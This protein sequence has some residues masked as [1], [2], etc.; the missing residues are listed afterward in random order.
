[1]GGD[2]ELSCCHP[3]CESPMDSR[4]NGQCMFCYKLFHYACLGLRAATSVVC[5]TCSESLVNR[6]KCEANVSEFQKL[7]DELEEVKNKCER[8]QKENDDLKA[9]IEKKKRK[10]HLVISDLMLKDVDSEKLENTEMINIPGARVNSVKKELDKLHGESFESVTHVVGTNNLCDIKEDPNKIPDVIEEFKV[11]V[12][13]TKAV[14]SKVLVSSVCPRLDDTKDLIE[15]FNVALQS[16]CE[17][18]EVTF[19]DNTKI[20]TLSNGDVNDGYLWGRGPQ[21]TKPAVNKL[22]R[23]LNITTLQD[24]TDV[25]KTRQETRGPSSYTPMPSEMEGSIPDHET[26]MIACVTMMTD[27]ET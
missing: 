12:N 2:E 7:K 19:V 16:M 14:T 22:V 25:T 24:V 9:K 10:N 27:H 3:S 21:L 26:K 4:K 13:G 20:F 5:K 8:L 15:P 18:C 1:M 23:N 11:L 6:N 17:D